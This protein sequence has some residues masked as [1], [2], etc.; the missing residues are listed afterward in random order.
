MRVRL[1]NKPGVGAVI[2]YC[3]WDVVRFEFEYRL[4]FNVDGDYRIFD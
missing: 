2:L 4:Q 3:L 1:L